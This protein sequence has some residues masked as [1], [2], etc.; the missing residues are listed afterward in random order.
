MRRL[1]CTALLLLCCA[2]GCIAAVVQPLPKRGQG[3]WDTYTLSVPG[4][5]TDVPE[6]VEENWQ[7]IRFAVSSHGVAW[8]VNHCLY[9]KVG[10]RWSYGYNNPHF[11]KVVCYRRDGITVEKANLFLNKILPAA[12]SLHT[13]RL[14]VK[15]VS[16]NLMISR[17]TG[18]FLGKMCKGVGIPAA[19]LEEGIPDADFVLYVGIA[20]Y[21][22]ATTVCS[23]NAEERPTSASIKFR[24]RDIVD[25]RHFTRIVA[26]EIGHGLGFNNRLMNSKEMLTLVTGG[27]Y[28]VQYEFRSTLMEK[29][30]RDH[31]GCHNA[32]GIRLENDA[33]HYY[34][35]HWDRRIAKD[36]LMSPYSGSSNGM[37]YTALTLAVFESTGHYK[38]NFSRA[39]N[40]SWGRNAGCDFLD[41]KCRDDNMSKY[42]GMFCNLK[43]TEE[44]QCTS[45]RFALGK[46]SKT[47]KSDALKWQHCLFNER[48]GPKMAELDDEC[49]IIKPLVRTSC[50]TG[51]A[52]IMPG[53][54]VSNTS[55]CLSRVEFVS[56][57]EVRSIGDIC[58]QVKCDGGKVHIR[59]KGNN[60]WHVCDN[61]TE[62]DVISPQSNDSALSSGVILCPKYS[63]VCM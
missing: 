62:N 16:G 40:M 26:H 1:L 61:E 12:I 59:Y 33:Q 22:P 14:K 24:P 2:Y 32:T 37:F 43:S 49:P 6:K 4:V 39:E 38:A 50:E 21:K 51:N 5:D 60:S 48:D 18:V 47:W 54:I 7:P 35:P 13:E 44:L 57:S 19:H 53:S 17:S 10:A 11:D 31:Y 56:D 34:Y 52:D 8:T 9:R 20:I 28:G 27:S 46:C 36:E 30:V 29:M 55:R 45:D 58:A 63:E 23:Y 3:P 41:K 15:R 25:T 42:S